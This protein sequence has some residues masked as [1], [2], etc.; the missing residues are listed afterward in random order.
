MLNKLPVQ[1]PHD[2]SLTVRECGTARTIRTVTTIVIQGLSG[3]R[4]D[5]PEFRD[6]GSGQP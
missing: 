1:L 2:S 5:D 6:E 4:I 3:I